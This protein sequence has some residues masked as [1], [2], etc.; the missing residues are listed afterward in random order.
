MT[1]NMFS[2]EN[3]PYLLAAQ[4]H[5]AKLQQSDD[6]S[7]FDVAARLR[8]AVE[9]ARAAEKKPNTDAPIFDAAAHRP[10]WRLS[11]QIADARRKKYEERDPAGRESGSITEIE[12]DADS[13]AWRHDK[14]K[15]QTTT[16][17]ASVEP[18]EAISDSCEK[19]RNEY[20]AYITSAWKQGKQ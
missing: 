13:G 19:A 5:R 15:K 9:A 12:E 8:T 18:E 10:G 4:T 20:D 7:I 1:D 11:S 2:D 6:E 17:E 3:R 16:H 14:R